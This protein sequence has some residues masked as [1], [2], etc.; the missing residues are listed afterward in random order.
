MPKGFGFTSGPEEEK[1]TCDINSNNRNHNHSSSTR[2][3]AARTTTPITRTRTRTRNRTQTSDR[4]NHK[5]TYKCKYN[6][7][8][9]AGSPEEQNARYQDM[10][11]TESKRNQ[12]RSNSNN[13]SNHLAALSPER[14]RCW[15]EKRPVIVRVCSFVKDLSSTIG[16]PW[17][18]S[19]RRR[20]G[21]LSVQVHLDRSGSNHEAQIGVET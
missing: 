19:C 18:I 7:K 12:R 11:H 20:S 8:K 5:Y 14:R 3:V 10:Q 6:N 2:P 13:S 4:N 16:S 21:Q 9:R 1:I 15:D 17:W